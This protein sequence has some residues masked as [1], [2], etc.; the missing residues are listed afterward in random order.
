MRSIQESI[1]RYK[2]NGILDILLQD[3]TTGQNIIWATDG[4]KD[5][6]PEY[7][8]TQPITADLITGEYS[9]VIKRRVERSKEEKKGRTAKK[10]EVFTPSWIVTKMIDEVDEA[11]WFGRK[12][13][14]VDENGEPTERVFPESDSDKM[15]AYIKS[16]RLEITCGEAP[17]LAMRYDTA[18]GEEIDVPHRQGMLDRKLRVAKELVTNRRPRDSVILSMDGI[19]A[20]KHTYG[21][22]FQGDNLL[23]ARINLMETYEEWADAFYGTEFDLDILKHAVILKSI[24]YIISWNLWQMNGLTGLVPFADETEA[25]AQLSLDTAQKPVR[26]QIMNWDTEQTIAYLDMLPDDKEE[27]KPKKKREAKKK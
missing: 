19:L 22:E 21:Y 23:I 10:A 3:H 11:G 17:Y 2:A 15:M 24:A 4:Y 18:T 26:C 7:G 9:G 6:G 8:P 27:K 16:N 13:V 25:E 1:D 14:F 12:N 20:F 5:M